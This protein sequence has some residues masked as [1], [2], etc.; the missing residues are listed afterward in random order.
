MSNFT[1]FC[2]FCTYKTTWKYNLIRH[3][4][5]KH[6][7]KDQILTNE[8]NVTDF[9]ENVTDFEE[10]VMNEQEKN[11]NNIDENDNNFY[12]LKKFPIYP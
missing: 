1:H 12:C 3:H 6:S 8:E 5:N 2:D 7:N 11:N 4:N 9:E 10:N